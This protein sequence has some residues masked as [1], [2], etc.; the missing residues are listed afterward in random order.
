MALF[1]FQLGKLKILIGSRIIVNELE[2]I[3]NIREVG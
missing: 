3:G 1:G 2:S